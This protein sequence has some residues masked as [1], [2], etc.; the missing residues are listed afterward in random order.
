MTDEELLDK[1]LGKAERHSS[2]TKIWRQSEKGKQSTR[3]NHLW[4]MYRL[5]L[6][7]YDKL[8]EFQNGRCAGCNRQPGLRRLAVDHCHS[9]GEIRGLLCWSCNNGLAFYDDD[10]DRLQK[11]AG[12]LRTPPATQALGLTVY[13]LLGKA[14][15]KKKMV[16]GGPQ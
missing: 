13:G 10:A 9:T 14:Q 1:V 5:T 3:K 7:Q 4:V 11:L 2:K 6:D 12:Y 15:R 16:Y 8:F